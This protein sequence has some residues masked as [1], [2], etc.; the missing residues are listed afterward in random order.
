VPTASQTPPPPRPTP[1]VEKVEVNVRTVLV[2]ITDAEGKP[3]STPPGPGD[4]EVREDGVAAQVLGVD[5]VRSTPVPPPG[6]AATPTSEPSPREAAVPA[7]AA[8]PQHLYVDTALLEVGSVTRLAAT[9][10]RNLDAI[11]ANGPLEI[12]VADPQPRQ[13]LASTRDPEAVRRALQNLGS[14]VSGKQG[15]ILIRR[16]TIDLL[17]NGNCVNYESQARMAAEQELRLLT[18]S[19]DRLLQWANSLGGQRPDVVYFASDGFDSDVTETYRQVILQ[20]SPTFALCQTVSTPEQA[21]MNLQLEYAPRSNELVGLTARSLA[22]LG[23]LAVP[24]A[25]GGNLK[26]LGGDAS[27]AGQDVLRLRLGAIPLFSRPIEP[28]RTLAQTTGG[29]VITSVAQVPS[30]LD[31]FGNAYVVSFR[32]ERPADGKTHDLAI[33]SR[34]PGLTIRAPTA[35]GAGTPEA[36]ARGLTVRALREPPTQTGLPVR[37]GIDGVQKIGKEYSGT[38]HVDADLASLLSSLAALQG[39]RV[40]LTIAVEVEDA[41]EAFTTNQEFDVGRDQTAWGAD[42]PLTWPRRTRKIAVTVE[43]LK[44]GARGTA[45]ADFPSAN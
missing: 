3:P 29:E 5:P 38:L 36:V 40:R 17:I 25:L 7:P 4:I 8:V 19:M 32:S 22:S 18:D 13:S 31:A 1:F 26:D 11:L 39:G 6:P 24:I 14:K 43:E 28:L 23:V 16:Q 44:T 12:V 9:F 42:V 27:I 20:A 34:R 33:T 30:M 10:D 21:T 45:S 37:V 2:R 41:R 35:L 15:L